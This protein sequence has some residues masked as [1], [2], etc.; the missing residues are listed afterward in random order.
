MALLL[1]KEPSRVVLCCFVD[2]GC[3]ARAYV[4]QR[5]EFA[6]QFVRKRRAVERVGVIPIPSRTAPSDVPLKML[7]YCSVL[8]LEL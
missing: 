6:L 2:V 1:I 5:L 4:A 3:F 7:S 8:R